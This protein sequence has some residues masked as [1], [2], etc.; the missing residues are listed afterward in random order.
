MCLVC[1]QIVSCFLNLA[2]ESF[3]VLITEMVRSGLSFFL[4]GLICNLVYSL[5]SFVD[6]YYI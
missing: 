3:T 5:A 4:I 1:F 6:Y 2:V